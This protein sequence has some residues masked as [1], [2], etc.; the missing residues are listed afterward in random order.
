M[1]SRKSQKSQTATADETDVV[2]SAIGPLSDA[3][4]NVAFFAFKPD[5]ASPNLLHGTV[6][7]VGHRDEWFSVC[8]GRLGRGQPQLD[9]EREARVLAQ[10][11]QILG[12]DYPQRDRRTNAP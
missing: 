9:P 1:S 7:R 11:G 8:L 6:Y 3:G 4:A 2:V 5:P 12:E 10:V